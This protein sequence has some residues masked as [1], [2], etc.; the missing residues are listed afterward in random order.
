M[1]VGDRGTGAN[2]AGASAASLCG[3]GLEALAQTAPVTSETWVHRRRSGISRPPAC[4]RGPDRLSEHLPFRVQIRYPSVDHP[5]RA[6]KARLAGHS[7][8]AAVAASFWIFWGRGGLC[9][10]RGMGFA[11]ERAKP[12]G[13]LR[14]QILKQHQLATRNARGVP[15]HRC[16]M[17]VN[18]TI[19]AR[20]GGHSCRQDGPECTPVRRASA[21]SMEGENAEI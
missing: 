5:H 10:F 7:V 4:P 17:A 12:V 19:L 9:R 6:N 1:S 16:G 8:T 11:A 14:R 20:S 2:P 13:A 3:D 21:G 18:F 15:F